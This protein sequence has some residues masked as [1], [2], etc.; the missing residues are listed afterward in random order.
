MACR[1]A[2]KFG[3][4]HASPDYSKIVASDFLK[5]IQYNLSLQRYQAL[6]IFGDII[7]KKCSSHSMLSMDSRATHTIVERNRKAR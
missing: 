5:D 2:E 7:T 1:P 6:I 4:S 3:N